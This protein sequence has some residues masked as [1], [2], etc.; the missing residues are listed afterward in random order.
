[1]A[2]ALLGD[3]LVGHRDAVAVRLELGGN[4]IAHWLERQRRDR[5]PDRVDAGEVLGVEHDL[6]GF[7][8]AGN[9]HHI[10]M[11]QARYRAF[12]LAQELEIGVGVVDQRLVRIE[13]RGLVIHRTPPTL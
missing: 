13:V 1:M 11:R 9:C 7:F 8:I 12:L 3:D 6:H 5:S 10:A 2:L 4:V